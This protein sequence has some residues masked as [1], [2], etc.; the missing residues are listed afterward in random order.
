[1]ATVCCISGRSELTFW[2]LV[3]QHWTNWTNTNA[4]FTEHCLGSYTII[5]SL[6][7]AS[8]TSSVPSLWIIIPASLFL[9][10]LRMLFVYHLSLVTTSVAEWY[11]LALWSSDHNR[12]QSGSSYFFG[13][14]GS[15]DKRNTASCALSLCSLLSP[16]LLPNK[17]LLFLFLL[18]Q[19]LFPQV[20]LSISLYVAEQGWASSSRIASPADVIL[21][22]TKH[23]GSL[24]FSIGALD[25]GSSNLRA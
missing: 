11:N 7:V 10:S 6:L 4:N 9:S 19:Y 21:S 14:Q 24:C 16:C 25:L 20:L 17:S 2:N 18:N 22:I 15:C 12:I 8:L 5:A 13:V 1:M 3:C 23:I